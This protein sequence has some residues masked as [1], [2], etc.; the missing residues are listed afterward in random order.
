MN[1]D[2]AFAKA[3]GGAEWLA[4]RGKDAALPVEAYYFAKGDGATGGLIGVGREGLGRAADAARAQQQKYS[5]RDQARQRE[6]PRERDAERK[7]E[8]AREPRHEGPSAPRRQEQ[9]SR[10]RSVPP[11]KTERPP[12]RPSSPNRESG[13]TR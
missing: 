6:R 13:R 8:Q 1:R 4:R 2:R 12:D 10:Q 5:A 11:P 7:P 3:Y 9:P